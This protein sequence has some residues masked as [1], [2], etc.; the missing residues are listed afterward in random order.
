L[1]Q[2]EFPPEL[3]KMRTL[4]TDFYNNMIDLTTNIICASCGCLHH[5]DKFEVFHIKNCKHAGLI[6]ESQNEVRKG[7]E[8]VR[9]CRVCGCH[10]VT[11][12]P[13]PKLQ[14]SVRAQ[15]AEGELAYLEIGKSLSLFTSA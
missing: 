5:A 1:Q 9:Y 10:I 7:S 13:L 12:Y 14:R 6:L 11:K 4:Y 15:L 2:E 3:P 8:A